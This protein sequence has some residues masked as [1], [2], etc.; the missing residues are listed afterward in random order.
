MR[1]LC[2][3][4]RDALPLRRFCQWVIDTMCNCRKKAAEA[5]A[6]AAAAPP[7][8]R[9]VAPQTGRRRGIVRSA[10]VRAAPPP[11]PPTLP[12][13]AQQR[14]ITV[15]IPPRRFGRNRGAPRTDTRLVPLE[16]LDTSLWGP[17]LWLVLHTM[18]TLT[19]DVG[20]ITTALRALDGA[21]PCPDCAAHYHAWLAGHPLPTT[22]TEVQEWVLTLHNAVNARA[23][24]PK[25]P[26]TTDAITA[27][28]TDFPAAVAALHSLHSQIGIGGWRALAATF[29]L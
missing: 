23:D 14:E 22:M 13:Y 7:A 25:A 17:A 1:C 19:T 5:A 27:T 10:P 26:W 3:Q 29:G 21:L 28:Y 16:I 2:A 8:E 12:A 24:P 20:Q 9:S 15:T 18:T 11:P 4:Q 6:A